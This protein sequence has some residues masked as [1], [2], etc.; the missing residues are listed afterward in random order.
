MLRLEGE[1]GAA[2]RDRMMRKGELMSLD[3]AVAFALAKV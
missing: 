2:D 1:L 3:E